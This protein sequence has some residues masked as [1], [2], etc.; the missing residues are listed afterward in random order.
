MINTNEIDEVWTVV[1]PYTGVGEGDMVG[2]APFGINGRVQKITTCKRNVPV[3]SIDITVLAH[4]F[5]HSYAHR[6]EFTMHNIYKWTL[7]NVW[8]KYLTSTGPSIDIAG[9]GNVHFPPNTTEEFRYNSDDE[10]ISYCNGFLKY[11]HFEFAR[12]TLSCTHWNCNPE[13]FYVWWLNHIPNNPGK[14]PDG[15]LN[16]WWIYV[17]DPDYTAQE[18]QRLQLDVKRADTND[19]GTVNTFDLAMLLENYQEQSSDD[20]SFSAQDIVSDGSI[21]ALDYSFMINQFGGETEPEELP[22]TE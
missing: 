7:D 3:M 12:D 20:P 11:P 19:D 17:N 18:A 1:F 22:V 10:K 15:R 9:C 4:F 13:G 21:N 16:N 14:A 2:P 8:G 6:V 5:I